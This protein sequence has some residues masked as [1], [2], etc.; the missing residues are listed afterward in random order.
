MGEEGA[1]LTCRCRGATCGVC[2]VWNLKLV[3]A[4]GLLL[5]CGVQNTGMSPNHQTD[6]RALDALD[7][8][9]FQIQGLESEN[10]LRGLKQELLVGESF[11]GVDYIRVLRRFG[12]LER[13]AALVG[14]TIL[15]QFPRIRRLIALQAGVL[16]Y[17]R[18]P[19]YVEEKVDGYNVRI[20]NHDGRLVVFT[21]GG[22]V[23]PFTND[24]LGDLLPVKRALALLNENPGLVLAGEVA[25]VGSPYNRGFPRFI[26]KDVQF[27][28]FDLFRSGVEAQRIPVDLKWGL[29]RKYRIPTVPLLG[30]LGELAVANGQIE[31]ER[32]R[33]GEGE[34]EDA[35][36]TGDVPYDRSFSVQQ[37]DQLMAM[38]QSVQERGGE[39]VVLKS[40]A[41]SQKSDEQYKYICPR[42]VIDHVGSASH[43][44]TEL[45][46]SFFI[47]R[48]FRS[49]FAINEFLEA[50]SAGRICLA[51]GGQRCRPRFEEGKGMMTPGAGIPAGDEAYLD[52]FYLSLGRA[53]MEPL[54]GSIRSVQG[55]EPV[56]DLFRVR[57][58]T[59]LA[60]RE[61]L[62]L[63]RR[64]DMKVRFRGIHQDSLDF[65]YVLRF[66]KIHDSVTQRIDG[67][68]QGVAL[69][70]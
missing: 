5:A 47:Q 43:L 19:L 28:A 3:I 52:S 16:R 45:D 29:F 26:D 13:G 7:P 24:R 2:L 50:A 53:V 56:K 15:G 59:L 67:C 30:V 12:P 32:G 61:M 31:S 42:Y 35:E 66:E 48:F 27:F 22:N 64:L 44:L 8:T 25:G 10:I 57:F 21:R 62:D 6:R 4:S 38:V 33:G 46:D 60:A 69:L 54:L 68:L 14:S 41:E 20:V 36:L 9:I 70:D 23:C 65:M 17:L 51:D 11:S 63:M 49:A 58:R 1:R 37:I 18:P 55:G 40:G 34:G 39:G